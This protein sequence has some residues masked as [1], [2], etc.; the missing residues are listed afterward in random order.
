MI[1]QLFFP[2][3]SEV[4]RLWRENR[5]SVADEHLAVANLRAIYQLFF[6]ARFAKKKQEQN[7]TICCVP[8]EEHEIGAELLSLYLESKDWDVVFIGHSAPE[9]EI[10]RT[11]SQNTPLAVVLSITMISHLPALNSLIQ[12]L[13]D[14]F[15]SLKILAG[16]GALRLQAKAI[17]QGL[18]DGVA[19]SFEECHK[20]LNKME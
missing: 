10:L 4:G 5:I 18:V 17:I 15:P 20:L 1:N 12:K 14:R 16:G 7:I 13:R 6:K 3:L 11:L 9:D 2:V 8:G 19:S